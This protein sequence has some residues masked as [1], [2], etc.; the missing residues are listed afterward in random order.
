MQAQNTE[1]ILLLR[2]RAKSHSAHGVYPLKVA[3]T[4]HSNISI[5]SHPHNVR[6]FIHIDER[7]MPSI[8]QSISLANF[9]HRLKLYAH[10]V[11]S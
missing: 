5:A 7:L 1:S 10:P 6:L 11:G 9:M 4:L 8:C 2:E 3:D